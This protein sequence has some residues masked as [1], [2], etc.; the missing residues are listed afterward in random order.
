M[1]N[2]P[3]N[4]LLTLKFRNKSL[5][6][7]SWKMLN[8]QKNSSKFFIRFNDKLSW[9]L[10]L[11]EVIIT[12]VIILDF[13]SVHLMFLGPLRAT[14]NMQWVI[15]GLQVW[16]YGLQQVFH[17]KTLIKFVK[18]GELLVNAIGWFDLNKQMKGKT[19]LRVTQSKNFSIKLTC[20]L[21]FFYF[22]FHCSVFLCFYL[23]R[24]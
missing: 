10:K 8:N 14:W 11:I 17:V 9:H 1:S 2:I 21:R 7:L 13:F 5:K 22:A 4:K 15:Y 16:F 19:Y 18:K 24:T 6:I 12:S 3:W 20:S 23:K